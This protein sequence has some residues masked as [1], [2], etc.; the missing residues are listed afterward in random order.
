MSTIQE[1]WPDFPGFGAK[2]IKQLRTRSAP[3][4]TTDPPSWLAP[5]PYPQAPVPASVSKKLYSSTVVSKP[6]MHWSNLSR[7][8]RPPQR[9]RDSK[10]G[11]PPHSGPLNPHKSGPISTPAP[12]ESSHI[13]RSR[14]ISP[15]VGPRSLP[16]KDGPISPPAHPGSIGPL[17]HHRLSHPHK[18][19]MQQPLSELNYMGKFLELL[20]SEQDAHSEILKQRYGV[21][22][23]LY[24]VNII[25]L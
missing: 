13:Q 3:P 6:H 4:T 10:V 15:P 21:V 16:Q 14:L 12:H 22:I 23:A 2:T 1:P 11:L 9:P 18:G 20:K 25:P 8:V 5:P 17:V 24:Y 7:P 19:V